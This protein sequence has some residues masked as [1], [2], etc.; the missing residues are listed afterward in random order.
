MNYLDKVG[1]QQLWQKIKEYFETKK[2][3][4][5]D[6]IRKIEVVESLP[7]IEEEGI[8]YLVKEQEIIEKE[9]LYYQDEEKDYT[10]SSGINYVFG[11]DSTIKF[12]NTPSNDASTFSHSFHANFNIEKQYKLILKYK[13]GNINVSGANLVN[14]FSLYKEDQT[15]R[16]AKV[17]INEKEGT[18]EITFTPPENGDKLYYIRAYVYANNEYQDLT[19]EIRIEEV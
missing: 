11:M 2:Y 14:S 19:Y 4:S 17:D 8:L 15:T 5:S 12:N 7:E 10:S 9:N 3:V 18:H 16:V 6:I 1:L 13:S